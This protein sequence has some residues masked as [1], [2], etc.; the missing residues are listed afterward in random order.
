M[1]GIVLLSFTGFERRGME[2]V[3]LLLGGWVLEIKSGW[4]KNRSLANNKVRRGNSTYLTI[5]VLMSSG[6][7]KSGDLKR[8][9]PRYPKQ[10]KTDNLAKPCS[11]KKKP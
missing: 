1:K 3:G 7:C 6:I 5:R 11:W 8:L 4:V 10:K 2:G 9:G